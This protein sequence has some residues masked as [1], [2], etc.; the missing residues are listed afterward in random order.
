MTENAKA[1]SPA[2]GAAMCGISRT[3]F[4]ELLKSEIPLRKIGRRSVILVSDIDRWLAS[5]PP[6]EGKHAP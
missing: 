4:Y 2:K 5:L 3:K 6:A 1:V